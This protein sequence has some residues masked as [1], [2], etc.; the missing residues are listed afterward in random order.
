MSDVDLNYWHAALWGL[1]EFSKRLDR[2][3]GKVVLK[4]SLPYLWWWDE[5]H[6]EVRKRILMSQTS[7]EGK[8]T[9]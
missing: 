1:V 9:V 4:R 8:A 2:D 5:L 7:Q 6:G 3:G